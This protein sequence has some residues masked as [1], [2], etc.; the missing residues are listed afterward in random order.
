M[1]ETSAENAL[2]ISHAL[3][4]ASRRNAKLRC[5]ADK[6]LELYRLAEDSQI[7]Q[8]PLIIHFWIVLNKPIRACSR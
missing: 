2:E 7:D 8:I 3:R 6:T 5:R 4:D 1:Q